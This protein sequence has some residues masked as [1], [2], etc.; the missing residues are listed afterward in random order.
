MMSIWLT[1][2]RGLFSHHGAECPREWFGVSTCS[3]PAALSRSIG[4]PTL[5]LL[6]DE[7]PSPLSDDRR[8]VALVTRVRLLAG[9]QVAVVVV[10]VAAAL[11]RG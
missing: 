3:P 5:R 9:A 7:L 2:L 10:L 6:L 1:E 11:L 4:R 8:I